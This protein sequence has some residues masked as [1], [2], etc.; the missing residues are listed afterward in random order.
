[1]VVLC[2]NVELL[3]NYRKFCV[4]SVA[5]T[6]AHVLLMRLFWC[7]ATFTWQVAKL[8]ILRAARYMHSVHSASGRGIENERDFRFDSC[9]FFIIQFPRAIPSDG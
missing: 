2:A 8:Y 1:M 9:T 7:V 3:C 6:I 5:I 4:R